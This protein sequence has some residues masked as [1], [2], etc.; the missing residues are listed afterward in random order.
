MWSSRARLEPAHRR[1]GL[2]DALN[3][4][5][6][7][8]ASKGRSTWG[9]AERLASATL[10]RREFRACGAKVCSPSWPVRQ[11]TES[12]AGDRRTLVV[13][14]GESIS[15]PLGC[16]AHHRLGNQ[17][18]AKASPTAGF[19]IPMRGALPAL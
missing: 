7:R 12:T 15:P 9:T 6:A 11:P 3:E 16:P 8:S 1:N 18:P 4:R 17:S 19:P 10:S 14:A 2:G 5:P 13:Y